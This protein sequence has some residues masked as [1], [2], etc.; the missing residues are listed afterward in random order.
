MQ[1]SLAN[2][3]TFHDEKARLRW[4]SFKCFKSTHLTLC[5]WRSH[6]VLCKQ[7]EK[8]IIYGHIYNETVSVHMRRRLSCSSIKKVLVWCL[9]LLLYNTTHSRSFENVDC[10]Q[11]SGKEGGYYAHITST[12]HLSSF[13]I[14]QFTDHPFHILNI[15]EVFVFVRWQQQLRLHVHTI[16]GVITRCWQNCCSL[17]NIC[18]KP[19]FLNATRTVYLYF[20]SKSF[21]Y[22]LWKQDCQKYSERNL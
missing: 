19:I 7:G 3:P 9:Q 1:I 21:S 16:S 2:M 15:Y 8:R 11:M 13:V 17:P 4:K 6:L 22:P 20:I 5:S 18:N 14:V 12:T 10:V